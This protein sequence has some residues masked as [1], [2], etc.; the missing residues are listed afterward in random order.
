MPNNNKKDITAWQK[1]VYNGKLDKNSQGP[2]Y[3]EEIHLYT[4][5]TLKRGLPK[6]GKHH[7]TTCD[8]PAIN[9]S[10]L[11]AA[12][13]VVVGSSL[14][15]EDVSTNKE[16]VSS[17]LGSADNTSIGK[18]QYNKRNII[19]PNGKRAYPALDVANPMENKRGGGGNPNSMM[20][21]TNHIL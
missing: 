19:L 2:F 11:T 6:R 10:K 16:I 15:E 18:A 14:S 17:P 7:K 12:Q 8:I 9:M 5:Q 1:R 20:I 13:E 4:Q 3:A 21:I